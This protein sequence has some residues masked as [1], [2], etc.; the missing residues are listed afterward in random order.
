[1]RLNRTKRKIVKG[2]ISP[3]IILEA[4]RAENI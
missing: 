2:K 3:N 4:I 1:M